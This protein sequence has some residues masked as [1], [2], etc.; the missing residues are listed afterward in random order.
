MKNMTL[1]SRQNQKLSLGHNNEGKSITL[2]SIKMNQTSEPSEQD[3][4][5]LEPLENTYEKGL[6]LKDQLNKLDIIY[7]SK[8]YG[9]AQDNL[10]H[11]TIT[12]AN[13]VEDR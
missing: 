7:N 10:G 6:P 2:P 12:V 5:P 1:K 11:S 8:V 9:I 4:Y 3:F 13:N